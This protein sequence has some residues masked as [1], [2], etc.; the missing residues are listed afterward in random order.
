LEHF[1]KHNNEV[2]RF[3]YENQLPLDS[4]NYERFV[5]TGLRLAQT[6]AKPTSQLCERFDQEYFE[7]RKNLSSE[8]AQS[9]YFMGLQER[10]ETINL[11]LPNLG[12]QIEERVVSSV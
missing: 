10:Q 9:L 5:E 11:I 3:A 12:L 6:I 7:A 2:T 1:V 4:Q 8:M